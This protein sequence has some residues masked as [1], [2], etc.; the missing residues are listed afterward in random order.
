M[1]KLSFSQATAFILCGV[2]ILLIAPL[3]VNPVKNL[4]AVAATPALPSQSKKFTA[5]KPTGEYR[6]AVFSFSALGKDYSI[7]ANG[8]VSTVTA[9]A[10]K[11][12][13]KLDLDEGFIANLSFM[14]YEGNLLLLTE[15]SD[16]DSGWGSIYSLGSKNSRLNWKAH[17]PGFNIGEALIEQKYA[18]ITAFGFVAKIDLNNGRYIWQ[19]KDLYKRNESFNNFAQPQIKGQ[20]VIFRG[21][22]FLA[23][24]Q[25]SIIVNKMSG[26]I[27]AIE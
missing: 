25:K 23:K 19:N 26:K 15:L 18:Y 7:A 5:V 20:K 11:K 8:Q 10:Q 22:S 13:F 27:L 14:E 2:S 17:I 6:D 24:V 9:N 12:N 1:N 4:I 16:H 3:E 21:E